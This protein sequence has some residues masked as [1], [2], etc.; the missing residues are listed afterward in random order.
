METTLEKNMPRILG[1]L[2]EE[3]GRK[4]FHSL[5]RLSKVVI[6]V[7]VG[8]KKDAKWNEIVIDSL[9]KIA[10]QKARTT[11]AKKSIATFKVR[12]G[13]VSGVTVTLRGAR[14]LGFLDKLVRAAIPRMRDFRGIDTKIVDD[15]GN[16]TIGIREHT[17]FPETADE[18][19]RNVFGMAIT[20][21]TTARTKAE[22]LSLLR[23]VGIP[24]KKS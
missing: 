11:V 15:M 18:D 7:G 21:A 16:A 2:K 6:S 20:I 4:N 19:N 9:G 12:E 5:P 23:L 13:D 1:K 10:G 24:F 22:A 14:M 17:I 3:L 8:K